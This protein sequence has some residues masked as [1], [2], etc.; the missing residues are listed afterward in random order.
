LL[1]VAKKRGT[2]TQ[3]KTC[4]LC[5]SQGP[6]TSEGFCYACH[7]KEVDKRTGGLLITIIVQDSDWERER[8][9][10][11]VRKKDTNHEQHI[12]YFADEIGRSIITEIQKKA[13]KI[14]IQGKLYA[15]K[16]VINHDDRYANWNALIDIRFLD[17]V[18]DD[19]YNRLLTQKGIHP[20]D[21]LIWS[22]IVTGFAPIQVVFDKSHS[23]YITSV[24]RYKSFFYKYGKG[25]L[26]IHYCRNGKVH[27]NYDDDNALY[28]LRDKSLLS[29]FGYSVAG[30]NLTEDERQGILEE[31]IETGLASK[32]D[33]LK[34]LKF[35]VQSHKSSSYMS[36]RK[37]WEKDV[38]FVSS[39]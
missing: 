9:Y 37:K 34:I 31:I 33:V 6:L 23:E 32:G 12:F 25:K 27:H 39:L 4:R 20:Q 16:E 7:N 30:N 28:D 17:V 1:A 14:E 36:A 19:Q 2:I 21:I 3:M 29:E 35:N 18:Q 26:G 15:I 22:D 10:V 11:T 8:F 38:E 13:E 5:G 24:S